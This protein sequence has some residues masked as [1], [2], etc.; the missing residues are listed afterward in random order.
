MERF[1]EIFKLFE[2]R[3][4]KELI[5]PLVADMVFLEEQLTE[6]RKY[7]FIKVH[8]EMPE[9]QKATPAAKQYKELLQQYTNIVKVLSKASDDKGAVEESPLRK[10]V[11]SIANKDKHDLDT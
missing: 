6:L 8:P 2:N 11:N 4:D 3:K 10:W 9:L 1:E 5:R 7:P